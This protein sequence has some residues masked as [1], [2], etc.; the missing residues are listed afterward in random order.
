MKE[1]G[2]HR[3]SKPQPIPI[4][5]KY[6]IGDGHEYDTEEEAHV[7]ALKRRA[8]SLLKALD[9]KP[10]RDGLYRRDLYDSLAVKVDEYRIWVYAEPNDHPQ[11]T[12]I[13]SF[14]LDGDRFQYWLQLT[15]GN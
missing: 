3:E 7:A 1:R 12:S 13:A 4:N 8:L 9:F 6:T 10:C 14:P 5:I 2:Q 15:D 11:Q